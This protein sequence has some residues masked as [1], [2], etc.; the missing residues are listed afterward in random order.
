MS[1]ENQ[2]FENRTSFL[3]READI[4]AGFMRAAMQN[5]YVDVTNNISPKSLDDLIECCG[6]CADKA[7]EQYRKRFD[8][9]LDDVCDYEGSLNGHEDS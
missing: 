8:K 3:F 1:Y 5:I 4:W 6:Q 2:E 9:I 7:L